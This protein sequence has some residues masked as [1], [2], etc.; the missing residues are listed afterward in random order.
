MKGISAHSLRGG[1]DELDKLI[2][3]PYDMRDYIPVPSPD[4]VFVP[5]LRHESDSGNLIYDSRVMRNTLGASKNSRN[6]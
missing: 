2:T 4:F 3:L 1:G 6:P 5:T